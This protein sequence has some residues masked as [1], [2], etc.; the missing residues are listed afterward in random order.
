MLRDEL[1]ELLSWRLGDRDDMGERI[2][3]EMRYTQEYQLEANI[4]LPWFLEVDSVGLTVTAGVP[5][6]D[7]PVDFLREIE[8]HFPRVYVSGQS[9]NLTKADLTTAEIWAT[10]TGIPKYY[11]IAGN[12]MS[13]S[14]VP[15]Q[16]YSIDWRYYGK[17]TPIHSTNEP[18]PWLVHAGDLVLALVGQAVAG[19]HLRDVKVAGE[20]A[21]DAVFAWARL[22]GAHMERREV[23]LERAMGMRP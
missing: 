21:N 17:S 15:D 3:A 5:Y 9:I 23:N 16:N 2:I 14:P 12:Q 11:S 10:G 8:G 13:F 6:M 22:E 20:F 7:L 4:W 19:K 18:T 1:V